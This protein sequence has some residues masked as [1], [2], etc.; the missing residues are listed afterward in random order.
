MVIVAKSYVWFLLAK[1]IF[2]YARNLLIEMC[3]E[4]IEEKI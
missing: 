4:A 3:D 1:Q 2:F